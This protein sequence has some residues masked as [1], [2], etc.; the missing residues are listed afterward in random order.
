MANAGIKPT[1]RQY[2]AARSVTAWYMRSYYG[3]TAD[4]GVANML[5]T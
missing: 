3:T 2:A 1:N 4:V 5:P